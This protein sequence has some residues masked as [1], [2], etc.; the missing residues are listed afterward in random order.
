MI[1]TVRNGATSTAE[2]MA[3]D[4]RIVSTGNVRF[5]ERLSPKKP[6]MSAP[7]NQPTENTVKTIPTVMRS[8]PIPSWRRVWRIGTIAMPKPAK[9]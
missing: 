3:M 8:N 1:T 4:Y 5:M 2:K 7:R 6:K 9:N